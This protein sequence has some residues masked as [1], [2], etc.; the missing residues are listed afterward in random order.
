MSGTRQGQRLLLPLLV[1]LLAFAA[2]AWQLGSV[3]PGWSDDELSNI[4][5]I[6]QKI[7][8]GDFAVY[9]TDATGLEAPYHVVSGL[10][11]RLFGFNA[12]GIRL[13]S[14]FLGTLTV[15]L[16][17]Q[18]GL[19]L[20][21]RR[22][23]LIAAA[24]LAVS[25]WSLIYSRVNLRHISLPV[26]ALAT[27]YLFWRGVRD[28]ADGRAPY[29]HFLL[30]GLLMGLAVYTYFAARGMPLI[31]GA[32]VLYLAMFDRTRLRQRWRG[33][34]LVFFLAALVALPLVVTLQREAGADARVA[35]VA[36]PLVQARAGNFEPLLRHVRVTLSMFH[37]DGDDEHL[38]NIPHRPVFG[39]PGAVFMWA[40]VLV[41][42]W[43]ALQPLRRLAPDGDGAARPEELA[44]AFLL[45]WWAAGITPGFLSVPPASL[46]HTILAQP[47]TYI[48][49]ALPLYPLSHLL[50][51]D[52]RRR[53][54]LAVTGLLLVT[55]IAWRDLPDY[56]LRWPQQG[57]VRFLYHAD[58]QDVARFV[59]LRGEPLDF[60]VSGL[61]AGPWERLA[62][63]L[64]LDNAGVA[65]AQPRW[66]HAQ[67]AAFLSL[68]GAEVTAFSG[69]PRVA[70]AYESLYWPLGPTAGDYQLAAVRV[71]PPSDASD[72]C[73][74][75][76]LCL[77]QAVYEPGEAGAQH[78]LHLTWRLQTPLQHPPLPLYS[79]PPP[80]GVYAGPRLLVFAQR[81]GAAGRFV[82]GDDGL[83]VDPLTLR[84]GDVF[85]QQ[86]HLGTDGNERGGY[87]LVGLYDPMD[88][89]R[90]LT[91]DGRDQVRLE[92][93]PR[94]EQ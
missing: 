7:F 36:V 52:K 42:A 34:A 1:V 84:P 60:A 51:A 19:R 93:S 90:I 63:Q 92:I 29:R 11:L 45:L 79:K 30:S 53:A 94:D 91:T 80:P 4:F 28:E 26:L 78:V 35:E 44:S 22:V 59:A 72:V 65:R 48:L 49:L 10:L 2:R 15:P 74:R 87:L 82:A 41:A 5:V 86:H 3:P 81:W 43:L 21:N 85:R 67:R 8:E 16:T 68:A 25:F 62:L 50:R 38:Y 6:A 70:R 77:L 47:A 75:N 14:S 64:A 54:A 69:Y 12:I 66:F 32:F 46:G 37:G 17:Y 18:M 56:F 39:A 58:V 9:Y 40:G 88:G 20:F 31:L 71:E 61:L 89:Q 27:F 55:S 23:G 73:F 13:L 76:G 83:W 57:M 24:A 33:V